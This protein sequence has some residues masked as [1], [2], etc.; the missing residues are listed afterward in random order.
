VQKKN[1]SYFPQTTLTVT[2]AVTVIVVLDGR[3]AVTSLFLVNSDR[4]SSIDPL[5]LQFAL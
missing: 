2:V 1:T 4:F 3:L 5:D